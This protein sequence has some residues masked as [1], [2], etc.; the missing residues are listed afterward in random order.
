MV[1]KSQKKIDKLSAQELIDSPI[2][3]IQ[4]LEDARIK[5]INGGAR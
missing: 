1:V 3:D 2:S 5:E 4:E